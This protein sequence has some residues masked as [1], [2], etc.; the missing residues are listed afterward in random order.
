MKKILINIKEDYLFF[1]YRSSINKEQ[2]NLLNTNIISDNELVFSEDY[3]N[4][5]QKY[6]VESAGLNPIKKQLKTIETIGISEDSKNTFDRFVDTFN[7][8]YKDIINKDIGGKVI[9]VTMRDLIYE[10]TP[11]SIIN[12]PCPPISKTI[13]NSPKKRY[14]QSFTKKLIPLNPCNNEYV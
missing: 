2:G 1:T 8:F 4:N 9:S 14:I 13:N 11:F 5:N 3:I 12:F 6:T 7:P 10:I